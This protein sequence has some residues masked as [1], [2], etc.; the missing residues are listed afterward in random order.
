MV[1][2]NARPE[3]NSV[4]RALIQAVLLKL[5]YC[6]EIISNVIKGSGGLTGT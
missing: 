6:S 3:H 4:G 2:A 5:E 1:S